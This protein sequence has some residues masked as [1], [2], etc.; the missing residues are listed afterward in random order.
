MRKVSWLVALLCFSNTTIAQEFVIGVEDTQ[1]R[2]LQWLVDNKY[3]GF[4]RD[5]LEAFAASR[6][7]EFTYL[8]LPVNRLFHDFVSEEVDFKYP[9]NAKWAPQVKK[10]ADILYSD[11]VLGYTDGALVK[12]ANLGNDI[13]V[14]GTVLGFTAWPYL[15]RLDEVLIVES[16]SFPGVLSMA[17]DGR[18]DAAYCNVDV[19]NYYLKSE[20]GAPGGLV[21]D[22]Q[23]PFAQGG[24]SFSSI[25]HHGVIEEF[26]EFLVNQKSVVDELKIKYDLTG[27]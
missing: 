15:D 21:F 4:N 19:A 27:E 3:E 6:N 17:L 25:K 9:D 1:Y 11:V 23:Q 7:Y 10:D 16:R 24:Y 13:E 20:L 5:V 8:P 2:P 18:T 22:K 12:P 26:N 14:L